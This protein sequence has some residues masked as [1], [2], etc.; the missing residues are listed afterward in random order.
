MGAW[1][2][3]PTEILSHF[4]VITFA[5][6]YHPG[7][8]TTNDYGVA[9]CIV[10]VVA[11]FLILRTKQDSPI[12]THRV[13]LNAN[14]GWKLFVLED[15]INFLTCGRWDRFEEIAPSFENHL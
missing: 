1:I 5:D 2:Y 10:A 6:G 15:S 3:L 7:L 8:R 13:I 12:N 14:F 4:H 11:E 9:L